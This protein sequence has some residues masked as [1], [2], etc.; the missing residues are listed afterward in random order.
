VSLAK[1]G[2]QEHGKLGIIGKGSAGLTASDH[3][4]I[5]LPGGEGPEFPVGVED[6]FE[7]LEPFRGQGARRIFLR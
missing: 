4:V 7:G 6:G 3:E 5:D 2:G 1:R